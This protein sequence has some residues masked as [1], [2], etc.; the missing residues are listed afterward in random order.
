MAGSL[1]AGLLSIAGSVTAR[2]LLSLGLS[3]VSIAGIAASIA[4]IKSALMGQ[5]AAAPP[6][7]LQLAGLA[8]AW[9]ALGLV[10][11]GVSFAVSYWGLTSA[12]RIAGVGS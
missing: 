12:V 2:V 6:A 10:L 3:V 11:G 5:L 1:L 9:D 8:G 7:M 4:G